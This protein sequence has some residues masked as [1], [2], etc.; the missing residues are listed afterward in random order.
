MSSLRI[1]TL[2][3][4]WLEAFVAVADVDNISQA[5]RNLGVNQ[6]TVTRYVQ[7]LEKWV[8]K[9]LL[10]TGG[11]HDPEDA[12]VS[13]GFTEEGLQFFEVAEMVI[14]AL[15]G[16]RS[17]EARYGAM[18][19]EVETLVAKLEA[20]LKAR[21][22]D[23]IETIRP[24]V[25]EFRRVINGFNSELPLDVMDKYR[26]VMRQFFASYELRC[27]DSARAKARQ[28]KRSVRIK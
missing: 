7:S 14:E 26:R 25:E 21:K 18:F 19:E 12:R 1:D 17:H 23:V 27:K 11:A 13:I 28:A 10:N 6:T 8:G 24:N 22:N 5:A 4:C 16:A 9:T 20:D 3:L 15:Q 2:R